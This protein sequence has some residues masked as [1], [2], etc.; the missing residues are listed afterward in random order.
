MLDYTFTEE[1]EKFRKLIR[2]F[3]LTELAPKASYYDKNAE[4]P[5]EQLQKMIQLRKKL[6][7][8]KENTLDLISLGI[9]VEEVG[10]A[11]FNCT[12]L[13]LY[14]FGTLKYFFKDAS[15]EVKQ[16]Y[17]EFFYSGEQIVGL[18]MTEPKSGGSDIGSLTT[19]A[20]PDGD[21]YIING[22]KTSITNMTATD[23]F[24]IFA[25]TPVKE[26]LWGI[27]GFLVDA[28][29]PGL[30]MKVYDDL[31]NRGN[32][33]G[34]LTLNNVRV[35]KENMI[36]QLHRGLTSI[37]N[38]LNI[39]KAFIGLMCLGAAQ[40]SLDETIEYV[41]NREAY[42][43][44]IA[45]FEGVSFPIVEAATFI[46]AARLLC[47]KVLWLEEKGLRNAKEGAMVKWWVPKLCSDIIWDCIVLHGHIGYSTELPLEKRFR[48]VLGWQIGDA[49]PQIQKLIVAREIFGKEFDLTRYTRRLKRENTKT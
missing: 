9:G 24:Y 37:L 21:D 42:N 1:Q 4:F 28:E 43:L 22:V 38:Y 7:Y 25:K 11:D 36:G 6:G 13:F 15:E 45:M 16:K 23:M 46:E 39:N 41:K 14:A 30:S 8:G 49:T 32:P 5:Y 48:D 40:Q 44:P 12:L 10:R 2:D 33:R 29:S 18:C 17:P 31:G 35:P 34:T 27:T 47:Y 3:A 26:G 20:I 19:T